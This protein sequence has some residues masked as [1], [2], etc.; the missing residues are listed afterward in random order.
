VFIERKRVAGFKPIYHLLTINESYVQNREC[1]NH[2]SNVR[3]GPS[4]IFSRGEQKLLVE[5][6]E[7]KYKHIITQKGNTVTIYK[8]REAAWRSSE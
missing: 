7:D 1:R 6:Y 8:N 3:K 2:G 4:G 5:V